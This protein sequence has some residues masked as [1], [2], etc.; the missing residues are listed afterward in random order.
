MIGL[1]DGGVA[2][3]GEGVGDAGDF[4]G[5]GVHA[6]HDGIGAFE[7]GGVGELDEDE[8]VTEVL[9]GNEAAGDFVEDF[10]SEAD[11]GGVGDDDE[12]GDANEEADEGGVGVSAEFEEAIEGAEEPSEE[13][14]DEPCEFVRLGA[15][16]LQKDG[17][18]GGAERDG[19]EGGDDGGDGDGE[20]ELFV[21]LA[22]DTGDKSG[23]DEHG[24]EDKGHGDD[25]TGDL[26]HGLDG[27]FARV[28]A[29]G[30][31]ALDIFDHDDGV[32]DDDADGEDEAEEGEVVEGESHGLHDGEGADEGDW[33]G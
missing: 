5:H 18:K 29:L 24:A 32:I 19:V 2:G 8:G 11:E 9:G 17:A 27:G 33:D 30:D 1:E 6:A 7:G 16:R 14:I 26:L 23:R 10:A 15:M 22:G 20:S 21:E 13:E 4:S 31:V 25:G 3:D 28:E 12:D